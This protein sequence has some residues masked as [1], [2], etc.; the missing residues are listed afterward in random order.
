MSRS[1]VDRLKDIVHSAE[2]AA[3]Y[4][5]DLDANALAAS[6]QTRDATLFRIA[7]IGEAVSHI[8]T[9]IQTLAPDIPCILYTPIGRSISIL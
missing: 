6:D 5:A 4:A 3:W 8:P 2:L 9:D 1:V 7:I